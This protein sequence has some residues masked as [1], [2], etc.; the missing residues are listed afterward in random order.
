MGK[1]FFKPWVGGNY[2]NGGIF[3]KRIL[4][5]GEAHICGGCGD[6]GKFE[7]ADECGDFTTNNCMDVLLS[8]EKASWTATF[9]KFEKSLVGHD[10]SLDES[11]EIWNSVAF[12]N[13]VQKSLDGSRKSPEWVDFCNSKDAFFEVLE[14]LRP[15]LIIVW[16]VTR[17]WNNMPSAGWDEGEAMVIDG[18]E[19][20]NG[21]YTLG[22]RHRVRAI[23]VYHPSAG[24]SWDWWNKVIKEVL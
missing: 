23:W 4:I 19:V 2:Q 3:K 1:I 18:Y 7:N 16:G 14:N 10:T 8:G 12:Y 21:W 9:R 17:M 20:K 13:Y 6:C 15:D 24:Y 5:L 11:R 22:N